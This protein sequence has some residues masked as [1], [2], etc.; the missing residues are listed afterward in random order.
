M[1]GE[2]PEAALLAEA[3]RALGWDGP[4]RLDRSSTTTWENIDQARLLVGDVD[5]I[6]ICSNGLHAMKAREYLRRQDPHLAALLAP[7]DEY[8]FGEMTLV[9]PVFATVGLWKLICARRST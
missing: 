4:I 8:R 9:K 6:I 7:A 2:I 3:V 5:R 1:K